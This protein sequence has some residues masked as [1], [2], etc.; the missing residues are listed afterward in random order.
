MAWDLS[1][2]ISKRLLRRV[3]D[4]LCKGCFDETA[5]KVATASPSTTARAEDV[6]SRA[7]RAR[8]S[9]QC[10]GSLLMS[11]CVQM[12]GAWRGPLRYK[13]VRFQALLD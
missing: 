9:G 1:R 2:S 10:S 6:P 7:N 4:S 12:D 13:M 3:A 5:Q 8:R 11:D